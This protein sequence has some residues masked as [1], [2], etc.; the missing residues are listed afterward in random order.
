MRIGFDSSSWTGLWMLL[1]PRA[2]FISESRT[3]IFS[4]WRWTS[5]KHTRGR[6]FISKPRRCSSRSQKV[7]EFEA[8]FTRTINPLARNW[9]RSDWTSQ[10][11]RKAIHPDN[12]R[13]LFEHQVRALP[14]RQT[15][16]AR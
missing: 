13:R 7:W 16:D 9:L 11:E 4:S 6:L 1:F 12:Q 5:L 8:F 15:T 3:R 10:D 2:S 14:S